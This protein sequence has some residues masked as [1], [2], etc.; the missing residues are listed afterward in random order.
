MSIIGNHFAYERKNTSAG[1]VY[2]WFHLPFHKNLVTLIIRIYIE[3]LSWRNRKYTWNRG[4]LQFDPPIKEKLNKHRP[5]ITWFVTEKLESDFQVSISYRWM[6]F[7]FLFSCYSK[8][9]S[10]QLHAPCLLKNDNHA[11]HG[12]T[13]N[14]FCHFAIKTQTP[15]CMKELFIN[16][17]TFLFIEV[18]WRIFGVWRNCF[19]CFI[20]CSY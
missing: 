20:W 17:V 7:L 14:W 1:T 8:I 3:S 11:I 6:G 4:T 9:D 15:L 18:T 2:S 13:I 12:N 10:C 16:F 5:R 19:H